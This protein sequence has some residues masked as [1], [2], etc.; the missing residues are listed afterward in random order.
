MPANTSPS[1]WSRRRWPVGRKSGQGR[2]GSNTHTCEKGLIAASGGRRESHP[3][4]APKHTANHVHEEVVPIQNEFDDLERSVIVQHALRAV[5]ERGLEALSGVW[6]DYVSA[7]ARRHFSRPTDL[8]DA[9][10][11]LLLK[12]VGGT[13][14]GQ[15]YS[16]QGY[17]HRTGHDMRRVALTHPRTFP[18][19]ATR[20]AAAPWLRP[21]LRDV[22]FVEQ[23][24]SRLLWFGLS[25]EQAADTY[26]AFVRFLLGHLLL[27][28]RA[29]TVLRAPISTSLRSDPP[30][31]IESAALL[32]LRPLLGQDQV[33]EEFEVALEHLLD[34]LELILA[35]R[36]IW[37]VAPSAPR[38]V[39]SFSAPSP[40]KF[41]HQVALHN[42]AP[43]DQQLDAFGP[44]G[45]DGFS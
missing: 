5:D 11:A 8:L 7:S 37:P 30:S 22:E 34:H 18:L 40:E 32:R 41:G 4:S 3:H 19:V 14:D 35:P 23:F 2:H 9:V 42:G 45:P 20:S 39:N 10:A 26:R 38:V 29:N 33:A 25:D 27:E 24:L 1:K 31:S 44:I 36:T 15:F 16:W 43:T 13:R 6:M 21:Q 28:A 12:E 17:L